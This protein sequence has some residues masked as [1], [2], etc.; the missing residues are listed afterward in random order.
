MR[1]I[2]RFQCSRKEGH[3]I[4]RDLVQGR[5]AGLA[6]ALFR[7]TAKLG[8]APTTDNTGQLGNRLCLNNRK[9]PWS[10][11]SRSTKCNKKLDSNTYSS[12]ACFSVLLWHCWLHFSQFRQHFFDALFTIIIVSF[13]SKTE[14]NVLLIQDLQFLI[15]QRFWFSDVRCRRNPTKVFDLHGFTLKDCTCAYVWFFGE[16]TSILRL[17]VWWIICSEDILNEI[18]LL[19]MKELRLLGAK[20]IRIHITELD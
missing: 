11:A 5:Q 12:F 16:N 6:L 14:W 7:R 19:K 4:P 9:P 2:Y 17:S 8:L 20:S 1:K 10:P 18:W 3:G 15:S 13:R